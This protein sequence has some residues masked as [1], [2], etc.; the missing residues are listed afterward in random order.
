MLSTTVA[1]LVSCGTTTPEV[2]GSE[3][4]TVKKD[5]ARIRNS[6]F[7]IFDDNDGKNLIITAPS[8]WAKANGSS[9]AGNAVSSKAASGI[10]NTSVENWDTYTVS[11]G[12]PHATEE[13]AEENWDE[14]TTR[15]KLEFIFNWKKES[16]DNVVYDLPFYDKEDDFF[17]YNVDFE[18]LPDCEN[19]L[20]HNG[21]D[22]DGDDTN[23]LMIHNTYSDAWGTAQKYTSSST[24]T[25]QPGT[26]AKFSVWVKT[27]NLTYGTVSGESQPVVADRGA[28]IGVTNTIGDKTLE[29]VQVKNIISD[30]WRQYTFYLTA[31]D[32]VESSFNL[33]LGLGQGGGNK[34]EYVDGYAFFDDVE[35]SVYDSKDIDVSS[36][37]ETL[38][39]GM[40]DDEKKL[41]ADQH[42]YATF[43]TFHIDHS[44]TS[45]LSSLNP[46]FDVKQTEEEKNGMVFT[47]GIDG[48]EDLALSGVYNKTQFLAIQDEK[49]A[50][51]AEEE[52]TKYPFDNAKFLALVSKS[53]A[54]YTADLQTT[55]TIESDSY[56]FLS[57]WLKTSDL[58]GGF[59]G[60]G[61][62]LICDKG[63]DTEETFT[64]FNNVTSDAAP[65]IEV[66]LP[67]GEKEE[68]LF[69]GWQRCC[70]LIKNE[71]D[72]AR[73]YQLSFTYGPTAIATTT[74]D[75]YR[76]GIALFA[77][78]QK[79]EL[80]K[81][82]FEYVVASNFVYVLDLSSGNVKTSAEF[83]SPAS[84]PTDAI[85]TQFANLKN[86]TGVYGGSNYVVWGGD[87]CAKNDYEYAGLINSDY[88]SAYATTYAQN[89][90]LTTAISDVLSTAKQPLL[91]YN[92][93]DLS[94]GYF[95]A[96][97]TIAVNSYA[98]VA[99]RVKASAGAIANIYLIENSET[100]YN[101]PLSIS[102]P[103]YVYWYDENGN[104]CAEDP[105]SS[106]FDKKFDVA[107][108]RNAQ[109]L[110]E[111][112]KNWKGYTADMDGKLYA[113]LDN[114][115]VDPETGNLLVGK[116]GVT[117]NYDSSVWEHAGNNGIAFYA[118]EVNGEYE[119]YAYESKE[120]KD[121]VYSLSSVSALTPRHDNS[122][123][124][125]V[126][127]VKT[128]VGTGEWTD[129]Y[130]YIHTGNQEKNYRLE[131]WSGNREGT[132]K[133]TAGSYVAF[134]MISWSVDETSFNNLLA[135]TIETLKDQNG[136][137]TD[138]AFKENYANCAYSTFSFFDSNKFLRYDETID[139]EDVGNSY[140]DYDPTIHTEGLVYLA[141]GD[142]LF[143]DYS[144]V[145]VTVAVDADVSVDVE[146]DDHEHETTTEDGM[147][148]LLFAT[149]IIL[150][151]ALLLAVVSLIVQK[152]VRKKHK[153][154]AGVRTYR[155]RP[156]KKD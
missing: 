99:V 33:V 132:E 138:E 116:N 34:W 22:Y 65:E 94:Y 125:S 39:V 82:Q 13:E 25:L 115:E 114:Y 69:D 23:V 9:S 7:E 46:S 29:Q 139:K 55:F 96:K 43:K 57:F 30:E 137:V 106:S 2:D 91:I 14:L 152:I 100:G 102:A 130:F 117:Y 37:N 101:D 108:K 111:V 56:V 88:A 119:Y 126:P 4:S 72:D 120:A 40:S 31:S 93:E 155:R 89:P 107:F 75:G 81:E 156:Q 87:S 104:V 52:L 133:S 54:P 113:N 6:K 10:V 51:F 73:N 109:G 121:R 95:G 124:T 84:V 19:P 35:C 18:D 83:D 53:G 63:Q 86:Y 38:T 17:Q 127:L 151:G 141:Y 11:S 12:L 66:D 97:Q 134:E 59:T 92:N 41:Y 143:V 21:A 62:N 20:T 129:V 103:K 80:N 71:S 70:L 60:V 61:V 28:Y 154:K 150:A 149:S 142:S 24:I 68:D 110:Y 32:Y 135:E 146:D 42:D 45:L 1:G 48:T 64:I 36:A 5:D 76:D 112:N 140:D 136:W 85:E 27:T 26:T 3:I 58:S 153:A 50:H 79:A 123:K 145:E 78:F 144:N 44:N 16:S 77:N 122:A 47:S 118:K 67:N 8:G 148:V 131:F 147:N 49:V 105:T 15:D 74:K 90:G 98:T 128:I